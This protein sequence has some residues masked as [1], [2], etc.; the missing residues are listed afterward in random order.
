MSDFVA[1]P[2]EG[3][4]RDLIRGQKHRFKIKNREETIPAEAGIQVDQLSAINS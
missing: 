4:N 3:M 1:I 2:Y